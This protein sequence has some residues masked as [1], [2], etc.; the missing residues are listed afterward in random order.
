MA[1]ILTTE[2]AGYAMNSPGAKMQADV[3]RQLS[4]RKYALVVGFWT[5]VAVLC[6]AE[7]YI[8]Q[9]VY[10]P[11]ISWGVAFR[12]SFEEWYTWAALS[13]GVLWL[14]NRFPYTK[15]SARRWYAIHVL[16]SIGASLTF[17][18]IYSWLLTGQRSVQDGSILEFGKLFKKFCL[19]YLLVSMTLYWLLVLAH[20]GW[21]YYRRYHERERQ[22]SALATELVQARLE[23]LRMQ[24]NPHFL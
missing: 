16:G 22:A 9:S 6:A 19:H 13:I 5:L 3:P 15:A 1:G 23:V 8:S 12:R 14:A 4:G 10:G 7:A 18:A 11:P 21:H 24:L 20:H 17:I 2:F